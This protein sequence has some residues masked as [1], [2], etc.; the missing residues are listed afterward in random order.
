MSKWR[1]SPRNCIY[2]IPDIHGAADLL[3]LILDRILPLR[4]SDGGK[5]QIVFL[6]DY[7]DRHK[8]SPRVLDMLIELEKKYPSQT[9]YLMGNHEYFI[10]QAL[11][12]LPGRVVTPQ[13]KHH[14][15]NMWLMNGGFDTVAAYMER[16]GLEVGWGGLPAHRILDIIPKAHIEFLQRCRK[17]YEI[18]DYV[19]V[20]GGMDPYVA[21]SGQDLEQL[22]WD[23]NLV[24][25]VQNMI[26]N[27]Q[28]PDWESIVITGHSV[29]PDKKPIIKEKYMMLDAGAPHQ[30]LVVELR[31]MEAYMAHPGNNRLVKYPLEETTTVATPF[32]RARG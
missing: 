26:R 2:V 24:K 9:A 19:F 18:D 20:H 29:Q 10:L 6:G 25:K 13:T 12:C 17:Y 16:A 14:A 23:R 30:L 22:V 31:S 1:P 15:M 5:D 21:A 4:K 3:Q 32:G 11:D 7:V 27:K 28:E 8:D